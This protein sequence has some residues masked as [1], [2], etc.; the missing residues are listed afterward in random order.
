MVLQHFLLYIQKM[1]V[2][3]A[4][5]CRAGIQ[6]QLTSFSISRKQYRRLLPTGF[7]CGGRA[8]I[9]GLPKSALFTKIHCLSEASYGFLRML[10]AASGRLRISLRRKRKP[11]GKQQ[12]GCLSLSCFAVWLFKANFL[13]HFI[14]LFCGFGFLGQASWDISLTCFAVLAF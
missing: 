14:D 1:H 4:R 3:I 5:I 2:S 10:L 9:S 6:S 11:G 12:A 8:E 7:S 13:E